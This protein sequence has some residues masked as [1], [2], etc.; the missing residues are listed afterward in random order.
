MTRDP[1]R[2]SLAE[3]YKHQIHWSVG[4][5]ECTVQVSPYGTLEKVL[6]DV[7]SDCQIDATAELMWRDDV[8][9]AVQELNSVLRELP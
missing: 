8:Q 2:A 5:V 3:P 1:M 9:E 6:I 4:D 7:D